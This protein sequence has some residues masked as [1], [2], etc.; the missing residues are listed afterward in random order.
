VSEETKEVGFRQARATKADLDAAMILCGMI[1][2]VDD[3]NFPRNFE[4]KFDGGDPEYFEEDDITHLRAFHRR[5][6]MLVRRH[7]AALQRVIYGMAVLC[8]PRNEIVDQDK[9]YLAPHPSKFT[10]L[11]AMAELLEF[12]ANFVHS[13]IGSTL[14]ICHEAPE[15]CVAKKAE[16]L[17]EKWKPKARESERP[18]ANPEHGVCDGCAE[19]GKAVQA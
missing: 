5:V 7:P 9:D 1:D 15:N 3:G 18:D 4:G 2:D 13:D 12:L 19:S 11:I 17:I 8:D 16:A 6:T 10:P 14:C